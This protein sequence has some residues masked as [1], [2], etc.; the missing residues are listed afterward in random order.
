MRWAN[1]DPNPLAQRLEEKANA[2]RAAAA[3][4]YKLQQQ[5]TSA[6]DHARIQALEQLDAMQQQPGQYPDTDHQYQYQQEYGQESLKRS[7]P[8][9]AAIENANSHQYI[10]CFS[11]QIRCTKAAKDGR[12]GGVCLFR[13]IVRP[14][15]QSDWSA[16]TR[17]GGGDAA[18]TA[19]TSWPGKA[20]GPS[21]WL[22]N[23]SA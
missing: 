15:S 19:G 14:H 23:Q 22:L 7:E 2:L 12:P 1:E 17:S 11:P 6:Q 9:Y 8:D 10:S 21:L 13:G 5:Q 20:T 18:R 3:V 16:R 4:Q